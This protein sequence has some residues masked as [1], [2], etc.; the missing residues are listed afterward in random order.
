[1]AAKASHWKQLQLKHYTLVSQ[2]FE[3]D[4]KIGDDEAE[5]EKMSAKVYSDRG[6]SG[7]VSY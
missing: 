4:N 3:E 6:T 2:R 7:S 5:L 1:M